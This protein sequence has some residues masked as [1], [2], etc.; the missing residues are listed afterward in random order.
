VVFQ[1]EGQVFFGSAGEANNPEF[2]AAAI[3]HDTVAG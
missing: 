3:F 1:A 2:A